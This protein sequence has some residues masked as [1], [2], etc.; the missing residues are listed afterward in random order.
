M[1]YRELEQERKLLWKDARGSIDRTG[2]VPTVEKRSESE[3]EYTSHLFRIKDYLYSLLWRLPLQV[4]VGHAYT[5]RDR[6]LHTEV[7]TISLH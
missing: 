1:N 3:L 2:H 7:A 4:T 5:P 6:Q